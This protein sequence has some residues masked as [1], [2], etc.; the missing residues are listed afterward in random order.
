MEKQRNMSKTFDISELPFTINLGD[1]KTL[2]LNIGKQ[3]GYFEYV[4]LKKALKT[5]ANLPPCD[6]E[7]I[8]QFEKD[9]EPEG[10]MKSILFN[11]SPA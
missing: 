10:S 2:T 4:A 1:G 11:S 6:L 5:G 7:F 3:R 8:K 9:Y